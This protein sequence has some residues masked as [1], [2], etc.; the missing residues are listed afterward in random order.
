MAQASG[1]GVV[2]PNAPRPVV[3]NP[4]TA[5]GGTTTPTL[6]VVLE[7]TQGEGLVSGSL[8]L[9]TSA[10]AAVGGSPT[11]TGAVQTGGQFSYT[12]PPNVLTVGTTY[13]WYVLAT[14][15]CVTSTGTT[16]TFTVTSSSNPA[17]P[18]NGPDSVTITGS[19]L[20]SETAQLS[21][22][23]CSGSPC[24]VATGGNFKVGGDG[25]NQWVT[26]LTPSLSAVP[27]GATI[28][29]ATLKLT[30]A[31]CLGGCQAD[32]LSVAQAEVPVSSE[33]TGPA[34]AADPPGMSNSAGA[35]TAVSYDVTP[36]VSAWSQGLFPSDGLLL[37]TTDETTAG[38][39]AT[40]Y[41]PSSAT[42]PAQL[43]VTY[44]P[45]TVPTAPTALTTTTGDGGAIVSW[46]E[47]SNTGYVDQ[48]GDSADGITSY[49]VTATGP[50]GT[51]A[52]TA[53]T[54]GN[55]VVL[56]G[57]TDATSYTIT[58]AAT[59]PVGTGPAVSA[60][61]VTPQ[62]VPSGDSQYTT[63]VSQLLTAGDQLEEGTYT[64]AS[65]AEAGDS[66]SAEFST[67]LSYQ[68]SADVAV[69][70]A[71]TNSDEADT[72]DS[73]AMTD[74]L[75][76][77]SSAANTVTV[78][79]VAEETFTTV[80]TSGGSSVSTPG[81]V[82]TPLS[83]TFALGGSTPA[84][85]QE[86]DADAIVDPVA[87]E[88]D[89][90]AYSVTLD[91]SDEEGGGASDPVPTSVGWTAAG[92]L[93]NSSDTIV[94]PSSGTRANLSG[95]ATWASNNATSK[96]DDGYSDDCTDFASRAL[97]RG[98]GLPEKLGWDYP[99]GYASDAHWYH[100]RFSHSYSWGGAFNNSDFFYRNNSNFLSSIWD[101]S[102]GDAIWVDWYGGQWRGCSS[103]TGENC[104]DHTGIISKVTSKNVYIDQH[105]PN[106]KNVPFF[107]VPGGVTTW[108]GSH[109]NLTIWVAIP[110]VN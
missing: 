69:N 13:Q 29:S 17:P 72:A 68:A 41:G 92:T 100:N 50:T 105:T 37:E 11:A 99:F 43:V 71:M 47:P 107:K 73:T 80:D 81:S 31:G 32:T 70:Q 28:D 22:T 86:A 34:L 87:S 102:P 75:V 74:T 6:S 48:S 1:C 110:H 90:T 39:G 78:Y 33:T 9:K 104:I 101:A 54:T 2:S 83:Y 40:Y 94:L 24:S 84:I 76:S 5:N 93:N 44:T 62:S 82:E 103:S 96:N 53:T 98:G 3:V 61:G 89:D 109:P 79:T 15:G 4:G 25:T 52:A 46:A 36:L 95:T 42:S 20:T 59:N 77:Y 19:A 58:V 49:S 97:H 8:Y 91:G 38:S 45:A 55:S 12:V 21:A 64:T 26:G 35:L 51:V 14:I 88:T 57:L 65:A 30:Q 67:W 23:A 60:S 10:G 108:A 106:V 27:A 85:S 56:T 63:A 18:S 7:S 66:E 16:Q